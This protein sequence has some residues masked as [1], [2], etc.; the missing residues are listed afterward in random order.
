M[1]AQQHKRLKQAM[2]KPAA[3]GII[4][5][6]VEG[7]LEFFVSLLANMT[8]SASVEGICG[9]TL[10]AKTLTAVEDISTFTFASTRIWAL[11]A[12]SILIPVKTFFWM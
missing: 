7:F 1:R 6:V 8:V 10:N 11:I 2:R 4:S 3:V 5:V 9:Q 12:K